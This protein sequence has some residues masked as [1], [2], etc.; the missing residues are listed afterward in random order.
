[1]GDASIANWIALVAALT[2]V[3][4]ALVAFSARIQAKR[5]AD[6]SAA[7]LEVMKREDFNRAAA[8]FRAQFT[9]AIHELRK[10]P[11]RN[12]G[13]AQTL[14]QQVLDNQEQAKILFEPYLDGR[15]LEEFE[16]AWQKYADWKW[17][18]DE[19][20]LDYHKGR[21]DIEDALERIGKLLSFAKPR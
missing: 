13:A 10:K 4:S 9:W 20:R 21:Q 3:G 11:P 2:A 19:G 7:Q 14:S 1:M 8:S 15:E 6:V 12:A 17:G 16:K 5:Q 18:A